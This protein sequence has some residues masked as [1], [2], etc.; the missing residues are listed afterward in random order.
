MSTHVDAQLLA[1]LERRLTPAER[2]RVAAHLDTCPRCRA[3]A[4]ELAETV[5]ELEAVPSALRGLP[6]RTA[7]QWP[8]VW[9]RVRAASPVR[10]LAPQVSVYLSLV[11]SVMAVLAVV[12]GMSHGAPA[13]V[14]AGVA[15]NPQLT[16]PA[17]VVFHSAETLRAA[18]T[19][20]NWRRTASGAAVP[21][22]A[23]TE[24]IAPAPI[25]TPGP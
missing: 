16:Q 14:T 23:G 15:A 12:P 17:T 10:K 11:T 22:A 21:T 4:R 5:A 13:S 8:A 1:L 7:Q 9:S 20:A 3:A 6:V 2:A 18:E 24:A 25:P 19:A